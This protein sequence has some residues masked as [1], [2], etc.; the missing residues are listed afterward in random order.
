[1]EKEKLSINT[2][3]PG[4]G[5]QEIGIKQSGCYEL[6]VA[7]TSEIEKDAVIAYAAIHNGLT[8]EMI[9][10]Y[11]D[12][13][14]REEMEGELREKNIGRHDKNVKDPFHWMKKAEERE[15]QKCWLACRLNKNLGD[16]SRISELPYADMWT[17][18]FP[19]QDISTAGKMKGFRKGSGTRSSLIWEQIRLL[20]TAAESGK[21]PKY[22]LLEN[23]SNLLTK[24][25]DG[26][27]VIKEELSSL[28]YN[29]Y[30]QILDAKDCGIPQSRKRTFVMCIRKDIDK[31]TFGFP[32][33]VPL[34][35]SLEDILEDEVDE[36]YYLKDEGMD[37]LFDELVDK[38]ILPDPES[39]DSIAAIR[40]GKWQREKTGTGDNGLMEAEAVAGEGLIVRGCRKFIAKHGYFPAIFVAKDQADVK[41]HVA[42]C[43]LTR[44][45]SLTN[46]NSMAVLGVVKVKDEK[47]NNSY[48]DGGSDTVHNREAAGHN[49][50]KGGDGMD[51][52]TCLKDG[53][54]EEILPGTVKKAGLTIEEAASGIYA[55][56][57]Q[58]KKSFIEIAVL[59]KYIKE[60]KLFLKD[61]TGEY[62]SIYQWAKAKFRFSKST[63]SRYLQISEQFPI[64]EETMEFEGK[65]KEFGLSQI[66]EI[67]PMKQ[68]Q[69]EK[70]MAGMTIQQIREIRNGGSGK[71][72][73]GREC[74]AEQAARKA[75]ATSPASGAEEIQPAE[76]ALQTYMPEFS[77]DEDRR[78]WLM[79]P[80]AWGPMWYRDENIGAQYYK[81]DFVNGC[82]LVAVKYRYSAPLC[83]LDQ[84]EG[85][86]NEKEADGT[87]CGEPCFHL[88]YSAEY[89]KKSGRDKEGLDRYYTGKTVPVDELEEFLKEAEEGE[90]AAW[91]E[92]GG[93][94]DLIPGQM[95]LAL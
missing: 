31:G 79:N 40:D 28:G 6:E 74:I 19:C 58:T 57:Q 7:S 92:C 54:Y 87:F 49:S 50:Q 2:L 44:C 48:V 71:P 78:E 21:A 66:I 5:M 52:I 94:R 56:L 22:I 68:E 67:L 53:E 69:R 60:R 63:V 13:P 4:I 72:K 20:R 41:N 33:P 46:A 64:N 16:I 32:Q 25:R 55:A 62:G 15:V 91:L 11:A 30:S 27:E 3:F 81:F 24:F 86:Q 26:W 18:S 47:E 80:E 1:M 59:L 84:L 9:D 89:L 29:S 14:S 83:A 23:V 90:K 61:R 39:G 95:Y 70:I 34:E 65:Y 75:Y 38:G 12:Y 73:S 93:G 85:S 45:G 77:G 17:V 10:S 37:R 82:R 76:D 43:L 88:I 8:N 35:D 51:G 36:K 42:R